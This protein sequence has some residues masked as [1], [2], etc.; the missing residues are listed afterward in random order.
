[1]TRLRLPAFALALLI[2][3][4]ARADLRTFDVDP[5]YQ[6]EVF[7][8]LTDVLTPDPQQ[9]LIMEAHGRVELLPSGQLLVNADN[10][11]LEQVEQVLQAIRA[12]RVPAAPRAE[13]RYWAVLG[14]R[15]PGANL[16][17]NAPP[18]ALGDV[19]AEL[20]RL[21]GDISF[22]V[23]GSATLVTEAGQ[24]GRVTG[25][26]LE[27]HQTV[28]VQGE[29][30]NAAIDMRLQGRMP[31]SAPGRAE[32]EIGGL[33]VRTALRRGEFVVLGQSEVVSEAVNGPVFFIVHWPGG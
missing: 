33:T 3:T 13:L 1:M 32:F 24:Q 23:I 14:S 12:G 18:S 7:A 28:F 27:V 11:T 4:A 21:H 22:R 15:A 31:A 16:P 20:E 5:Q 9:G 17:G 19:L 2:A 10:A 26:A 25:M 6:Q 30:L 8:A 29:A